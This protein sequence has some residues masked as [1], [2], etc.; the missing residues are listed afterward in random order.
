MFYILKLGSRSD[1]SRLTMMQVQHPT[2]RHSTNSFASPGPSWRHPSQETLN[3]NV[4]HNVR[5]RA[6]IDT[7]KSN[8]V[9]IFKVSKD[10]LTFCFSF[11]NYR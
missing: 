5:Q 8:N 11:K 10:F 7:G 6:S 1:F 2:R 4:Y 9:Y 3:A